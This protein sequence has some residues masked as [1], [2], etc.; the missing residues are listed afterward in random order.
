M[1]THDDRRVLDSATSNSALSPR[2][3]QAI[4]EVLAATPA[5]PTPVREPHTLAKLTNE[6][7]LSIR[8]RLA[9]GSN[10]PEDRPSALAHEYGVTRMTLHNLRVGRTW[11]HLPL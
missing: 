4:G 11:K 3:K 10:K 2:L 8:Q 7:V 9:S 5:V 1:F 6:Q